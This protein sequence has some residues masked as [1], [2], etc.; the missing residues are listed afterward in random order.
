MFRK[1]EK[2]TKFYSS[3]RWK[4]LAAYVM[5]RDSYTCVRC[6]LKPAQVVHHKV[7]LNDGNVDDAEV[8]LNPELLESLCLDC[9][10]FEHFG[11]HESMRRP[12]YF[13]KSGQ[14]RVT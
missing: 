8:S 14:P 11:E 3:A 4:K 10:N 12:L 1:T 9:H 7:W 5:A 13:D 6:K 2:L